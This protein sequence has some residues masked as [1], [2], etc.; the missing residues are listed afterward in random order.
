M[1]K[2][3]RSGEMMRYSKNS[4]SVIL[5]LFGSKGLRVC[6][7]IVAFFLLQSMS[8]VNVAAY[9]TLIAS[10]LFAANEKL[11][12]S[13]PQ[14]KSTQ[15]TQI[16]LFSALYT[17]VAL[18]W[19]TGLKYIG[20]LGTILLTDY[21]F[22]TYP[23]LFNNIQSGNFIGNDIGRATLMLIIGYIT[24][25]LFGSVATENG[26][27]LIGYQL[28]LF[29]GLCLF[30][31]S[32]LGYKSGMIYKWHHSGS[33]DNSGSSTI[34][35]RQSPWKSKIYVLGL[36]GSS[37]ILFS[38][39]LLEYLI[40]TPS[41]Y[42]NINSLA[43]IPTFYQFIQLLF[44]SL[45]GIFLNHHF[46]TVIEQQLG[47]LI[48][49]KA[50]LTASFILCILIG[51]FYG[52]STLFTP[53]II[54]S[55]ILI[56][57]GME[58]NINN[59]IH[60]LFS[61][62]GGAGGYMDQVGGIIGS[63][64][65]VGAI[66]GTGLTSAGAANIM[67]DIVKQIIEKPTSRRIFTFL[68][69]NLMFMF[70]EM[71][72]GIWTNSLGL[73]TD[74]C[75]MLFDATA[76]FIALVAEVISQWKPTE[77][78]SYGYGRVQILSG[79]VNGIF[80]IFIAITILMESIERLMEP[81]EINTDKLLLVSVLG[82]LVNMVGVFS[83]HGD[84][85]HSHGGGGGG[86]SHGHH[87]H[88]H[89]GSAHDE[90]NQPKKRSVNIDGVF[91]HL[92]ADTLGSVGVIV[93]SLIIQIWGYTLADPIC[94]LCISILIFLSVIPLITNTAK[95]L[96][97]CTP[98]PIHENINQIIGQI[99]NITGVIGY[100]DFHFWSHSEEIVVGTIKVIADPAASEK[101]LRKSIA[102]VLKENKV[103]SPTIEI[104]KNKQSLT[105]ST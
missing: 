1:K 103:T 43:F 57:T 17:V 5:L 12:L 104:I 65:M 102:A 83:F 32:L 38:L 40:S 55:F 101:K 69:V 10:L 49:S 48:F 24:I 78:F 70:V 22:E 56:I 34:G 97:Q 60:I 54:G 21:T 41:I 35:A 94:S 15:L 79:F 90:P 76:L 8:V 99:T 46:D 26:L 64:P 7:V 3:V 20:P 39:K 4:Q 88:S 6:S 44:I 37:V 11:W 84:H 58:N 77:S 105:E 50:S 80:L 13:I 42:N 86:H 52:F 74:A 19:N 62:S 73:I 72:Y 95:T 51:L 68:V 30:I 18:L 47:F 61:K 67:K 59:T 100:T 91:L 96:L 14:L 25:P 85:G 33:L 31:Y 53:F 63:M 87:G 98:E 16:A 36:L 81:P 2:H 92:L 29:G 71:A 45:F 23:V 93:S 28:P 9:T 75:H 89:G 66:G 27:P 82:F